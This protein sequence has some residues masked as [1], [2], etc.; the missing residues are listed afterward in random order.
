VRRPNGR[1][2][3]TVGL[4]L[5]AGLVLALSGCGQPAYR[6][7]G[8]SDRDSILRVP[9][10]WKP[11]DTDAALKATGV[12]PSTQTGWTVFYDGS[13]KPGVAHVA[14]ASTADPVLIAET[15]P[16]TKEQG[17]SVTGSD[18][19]ELLL[20]WTADQRAQATKDKVFT[21]L[22]NQ[23]VAKPGERG[24]HVKYSV[25]IGPTTTEIFDRVALIDPKHKGVHIAFVHCT[26]TCYTAHQAEISGVVNSL[27]LKSTN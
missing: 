2:A 25:V 7:V 21:M 20:P 1:L 19:I 5:V 8:S 14:T 3:R 23:S 12:D 9:R 4:L 10:A 17:A 13:S 26:E 27:T 24:A 15:I 6:F 18:L 11:V 16:L 22:E